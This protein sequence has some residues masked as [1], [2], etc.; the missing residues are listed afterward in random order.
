MRAI[1]LHPAVAVPT[2]FQPGGT[3]AATAQVQLPSTTEFRECPA[4][5][6]VTIRGQRCRILPQVGETVGDDLPVFPAGRREHEDIVPARNQVSN[7]RTGVER[8]IIGMREHEEHAFR[9]TGLL[10]D[11][12]LCPNTPAPQINALCCAIAVH[13]PVHST[14]AHCPGDG[15]FVDISEQT[16]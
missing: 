9:F 11:L 7:R 12:P 6:L 16:H 14:Q 15:F 3:S 8:L 1:P 10:H 13:T 4:K 2:Q 5:F